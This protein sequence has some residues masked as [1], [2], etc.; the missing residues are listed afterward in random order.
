MK[1]NSALS[2][3][4]IGMIA[5]SGLYA[6]PVA[7]LNQSFE[8][9]D[10]NARSMA[11]SGKSAAYEDFFTAS[12]ATS[13]FL[14]WTIVSPTTDTTKC[15]AGLQTKYGTVCETEPNGIQHFYSQLYP[16]SVDPNYNNIRITSAALV[17]TAVSGQEYTLE[18]FARDQQYWG[19]D[20][21]VTAKLFFNGVAKAQYTIHYPSGR[22]VPQ[23]AIDENGETPWKKY[24]LPRY[25]AAGGDAGQTIT[26]EFYGV[27]GTATTDGDYPAKYMQFNIDMVTLNAEAASIV[28]AKDPVPV[29]GQLNTGLLGQL[30]WTPPAGA[31]QHKV[32]FGTSPTPSTLVYTGT[33]TSYSI[34]TPAISMKYDAAYYWRVDEVVGATTYP[35]DVWSFNTGKAICTKYMSGDMNG[36]CQVNFADFAIMAAHW[37]DCTRFNAPCP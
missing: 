35:G 29:N 14:K 8:A 30:S 7:I 11:N 27:G 10:V 6:A 26:I 33:N 24:R 3:I 28:K 34:P 5:T 12:L 2:V 25:M 13:T 1:M 20:A 18:F 4:M 16:M 31:T 15:N 19:C 23:E 32:Y 17:D 22:P 21:D 37:L 36:D 9:P